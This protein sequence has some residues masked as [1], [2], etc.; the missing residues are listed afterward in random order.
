[1]SHIKIEDYAERE[2]R[3]CDYKASNGKTYQFKIYR[4]NYSV[5]WMCQ[6]TGENCAMCH[7]PEPHLT[8]AGAKRNGVKFLEAALKQRG[9]LNDELDRRRASSRNL[10]GVR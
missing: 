4:A 5:A 10:R 7:H 8:A 6:I 3:S 2:D 9:A 1:M